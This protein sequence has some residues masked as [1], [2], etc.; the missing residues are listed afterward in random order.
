MM[1]S[2]R[3]LR[4]AVGSGSASREAGL[5]KMQLASYEVGRVIDKVG[6]P[7][8]K[9]LGRASVRRTA[10]RTNLLFAVGCACNR[11]GGKLTI[12]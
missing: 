3:S 5:S 6:R 4:R 7:G 10:L 11:I 12:K 1:F 2:S 8:V 9:G